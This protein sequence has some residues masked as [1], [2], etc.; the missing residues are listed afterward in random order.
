LGLGS[1]PASGKNAPGGSRK[2]TGRRQNRK[3]GE[4]Y[5]RELVWKKRGGKKNEGRRGKTDQHYD[6]K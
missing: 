3:K 5:W 2:Q 4:D 6:G 1:E